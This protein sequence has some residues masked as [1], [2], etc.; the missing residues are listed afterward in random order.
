M[1][2]EVGMERRP[3]GHLGDMASQ[4]ASADA[5]HAQ[6]AHLEGTVT[7][8]SVLDQ[9]LLGRNRHAACRS[10]GGWG[11]VEVGSDLNLLPMQLAADKNISKAQQVALPRR[12][13]QNMQAAARR[14]I[15]GDNDVGVGGHGERLVQ[16][17]TH[18]KPVAAQLPAGCVCREL[19]LSEGNT[20]H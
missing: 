4:P 3:A 11:G 10:F 16:L 19:D 7:L 17:L 20:L 6:P 5:K 2:S 12:R 9:R 14:T 8:A 13:L 15:G 18:V 1:E